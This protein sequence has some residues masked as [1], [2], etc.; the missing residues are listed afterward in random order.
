MPQPGD[1]S[2]FSPVERWLLGEVRDCTFAATFCASKGRTE[3]DHPEP[4]NDVCHDFASH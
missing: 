1:L 4:F 2:P 3:E